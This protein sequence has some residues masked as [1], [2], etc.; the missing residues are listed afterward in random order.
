MDGEVG[1]CVLSLA[2]L[3]PCLGRH[4]V[5]QHLRRVS[6]GPGLCLSSRIVLTT[7]QIQCKGPAGVGV[8]NP[9]RSSSRFEANQDRWL[10]GTPV[11]LFVSNRVLQQLRPGQVIFQ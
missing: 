1:T 5:A 11:V 8:R 4:S 2:G 6:Q 7:S 9:G 3:A 10:A